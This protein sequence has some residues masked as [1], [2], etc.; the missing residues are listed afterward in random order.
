MRRFIKQDGIEDVF[1]DDVKDKIKTITANGA[2]IDSALEDYGMRVA[3][4]VLMCDESE[5]GEVEIDP[6]DS[7]AYIEIYCT[8][9]DKL[10]LMRAEAKISEV[11]LAGQDIYLS[12]YL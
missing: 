2:T 12:E 1:G 7:T 10:Y 5:L 9:G 4:E 8:K 3:D 6:A 11:R